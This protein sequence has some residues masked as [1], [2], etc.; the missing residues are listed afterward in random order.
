MEE[1][2]PGEDQATTAKVP[3]PP[4]KPREA[5]LPHQR[6]PRQG[7]NEFQ[8]YRS[9][10]AE[11]KGNPAASLER[12]R[13]SGGRDYVGESQEGNVNQRSQSEILR[14]YSRSGQCNES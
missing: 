6:E 2:P 1:P 7:Q 4:R 14:Q 3:T 13:N 9:N 5:T 10:V 11:A 8:L 12:N